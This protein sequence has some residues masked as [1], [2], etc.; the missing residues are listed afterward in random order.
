MIAD[1]VTEE[2]MAAWTVTKPKRAYLLVT[3]P[4][5]KADDE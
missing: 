2:M 3:A 5:G 1:G 4:G